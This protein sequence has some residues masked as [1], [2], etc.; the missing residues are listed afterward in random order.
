[1]NSLLYMVYEYSIHLDFQLVHH[2]F[3]YAGETAAGTSLAGAD[4]IVRHFVVERVGP[5]GRIAERRGHTGVVNETEFL[6][7]QELAVPA[8][9]QEW[10]ADAADVLHGHVGETVDDVGLADHLVEPVF[11]CCVSRPPIFR[12]PMT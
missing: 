8:D 1:M 5:K 2:H 12:L 6:H 3:P 9:A 10:N 7:H 11:N 4:T